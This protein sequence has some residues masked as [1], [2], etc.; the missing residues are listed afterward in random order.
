MKE[1]HIALLVD[2]PQTARG[3][4]AWHEQAGLEDNEVVGGHTGFVGRGRVPEATSQTV[5]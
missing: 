1:D 5:L 2:A 3:F 4:R